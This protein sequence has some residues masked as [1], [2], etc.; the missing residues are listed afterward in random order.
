MDCFVASFLATAANMRSRSRDM[1]LEKSEIF[2]I[3]V[4]DAISANQK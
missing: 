4:L 3:L 1:T 2:L